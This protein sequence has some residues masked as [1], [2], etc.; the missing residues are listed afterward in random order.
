MLTRITRSE[1]PW[2]KEFF[3]IS[4]FSVVVQQFDQMAVL[5]I[6][7]AEIFFAKPSRLNR[8]HSQKPP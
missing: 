8:K 1:K 6:E 7:D 2:C 4:L 5:D 3:L